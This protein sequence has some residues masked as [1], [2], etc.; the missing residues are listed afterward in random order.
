MKEKYKII[1]IDR[2]L[3]NKDLKIIKE[4]EEK[5]PKKDTCNRWSV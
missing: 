5:F 4:I 1:E 3:E 2:N